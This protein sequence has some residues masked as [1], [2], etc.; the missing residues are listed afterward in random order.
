MEMR[1]AGKFPFEKAASLLFYS[2][3]SA[4]ATLMHDLKYRNY[5]KLAQYMGEILGNELLSSGFFSDIDL[6]IPVPMHFLKKAKR[7]YNQTQEIASGLSKVVTIPVDRSLIA[8]KPHSSQTGKSREERLGNLKNVFK[9]KS[10]D[11]IKNK[12]ILLLDDVCTTGTTL[13]SAAEKILDESPSTRISLLTLG[14]T[15]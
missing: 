15:F 6:I 14:V 9:L 12:H 11:T 1:F 13:S 2:S 7:G 4:V 10:A 8:A 3:D 5:R